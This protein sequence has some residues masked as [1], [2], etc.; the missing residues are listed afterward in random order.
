VF[1]VHDVVRRAHSFE[2]AAHAVLAIHEAAASRIVH[3][4]HTYQQL[5]GLSLQQDELFRQALRCVESELFRAAH[6]MAWAG[7]MDFF[8][9]K[10]ASDGFAKLRAA[11]AKWQFAAV[12]E[13]RE[14]YTEHQ[15][16][17]ASRETGL[18]R[19]NE[20]KA[21][22]GLLNKRNECAHPSDYFP[23]LNE[24]LGFVSELLRRIATIQRRPY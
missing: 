16:I 14:C 11:R 2:K 17:E 22:H 15:I 10:L 19:K 21:L 5:K 4:E 6:V 3:L 13:L 23:D 12:E 1:H 20:M 24:T 7:F 18:C 9:E 8:E